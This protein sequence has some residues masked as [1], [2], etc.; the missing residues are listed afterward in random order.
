MDIYTVSFFGHRQIED[1]ATVELRLENL[2]RELLAK[3]EYIEFLVGRNGE[4]DQMSASTVRRLRRTVRDD[5]SS[6]TLV[7]PYLTAE[8]TNNQKSFDEY[9]DSIE[10]C[11][12]AAKAH[13][14]SAL[15]IR[16]REMVDRSD[17]VV[18]C[19]ERK[20]GGT[21]QTIQYAD[22]SGKTIINVMRDTPQIVSPSFFKQ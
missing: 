22:R 9:Y 11:E 3:K 19:I 1:F 8:Y 15:Q 6:L 7:L 10:I 17:L 5:N 21:Y 18:C 16:N 2:I 12:N 14:K 13:F 20:Y 4:F